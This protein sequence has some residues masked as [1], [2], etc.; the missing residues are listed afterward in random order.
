MNFT[1]A[2]KAI[3]F[4]LESPDLR[5]TPEAAEEA[6]AAMMLLEQLP[7]LVT[8]RYSG[9]HRTEFRAD[10]IRASSISASAARSKV[11]GWKS[12]HIPGFGSCTPLPAHQLVADVSTLLRDRPQW[13][14]LTEPEKARRRSL[15]AARKRRKELREQVRRVMNGDAI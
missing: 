10:S 4:A 8:A 9:S 15:S 12:I 2:C 3:E 5:M 6:R 7:A 1:N 14:R 13:A 11:Q